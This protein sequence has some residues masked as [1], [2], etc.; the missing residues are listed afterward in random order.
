METNMINLME[1]IPVIAITILI[2]SWA[3]AYLML[4]GRAKSI[5]ELNETIDGL[6]GKV[7][8]S[9]KDQQEVQSKAD[10]FES[11]SEE[12]QNLIDHVNVGA[13]PNTRMLLSGSLFW[14][15]GW[16]VSAFRWC[17][18]VTVCRRTGYMRGV[19]T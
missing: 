2:L 15:A 1:F 14:K 4:Q 9:V 18:S 19:E 8:L 5:K 12:R 7:D 6:A 3:I 16:M 11:L 17:R 13:V 10:R